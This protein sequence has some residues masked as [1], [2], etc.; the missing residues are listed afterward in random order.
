MAADV[1]TEFEWPPL[2]RRAPLP[3]GVSPE[4]RQA[5]QRSAEQLTHRSLAA[6]RALCDGV[7]NSLGSRQLARRSL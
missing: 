7:Q 6:Q 4:A 3:L 2:L 1:D 5:L